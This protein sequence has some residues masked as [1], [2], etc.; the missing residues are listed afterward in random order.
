METFALTFAPYGN[1]YVSI[2]PPYKWVLKHIQI[3]KFSIEKYSPPYRG[4][5]ERFPLPFGPYG[6]LYVSIGPPIN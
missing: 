4:H 1:L 5:M 3:Y 2:G 6:N